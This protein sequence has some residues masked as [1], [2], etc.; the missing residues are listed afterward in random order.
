[1][2]IEWPSGEVDIFE[3]VQINQQLSVT[4]GETE[5]VLGGEDALAAG[6]KLYPNP[7]ANQLNFSVQGMDNTVVTIVDM[8]G[9]LVLSTTVS[10]A[11][12]IDVSSLNTGV[13]FA[14]FEIDQR[15]VSYK[16][17]KK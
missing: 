16:F 5:V 4:E 12:S 6:I 9:K 1:M 13:Y 10:S 11:N 15:Q 8:N 2:I 17:V 7:T 3:D 14:Q